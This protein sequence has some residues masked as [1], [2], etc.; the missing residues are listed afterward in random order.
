MRQGDFPAP[1]RLDASV[2]AA[3]EA[4]C[5]K[6]MTLKPSDRYPS[7]RALADDIERWLADEPVAAYR[8][9]LLA[10]ISRGAR[11]HKVAAASASALLVAAVV[12]L[13]AGTFLLGREQQR[14][15]KARG[16]AQ[17]N[18]ER[19]EKARDAE[20]KARH[21]A[22]D[23]RGKADAAKRQV[24]RQL[25]LSYLDRGVN[26]MER[27]D[28]LQGY[29]ILGQAYHAASECADLRAST[30][31]SWAPGTSTCLAYSGTKARSLPWRSARTGRRSPPRA[32]TGQRGCG[33]QR[34]ANR[35]ARQ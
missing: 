26:E 24:Q 25:I 16:D 6:A 35:W 33:T 17:T 7:A 20:S 19:A 18:Y 4:I 30:R 29:A 13:S 14:T 34:R 5:L 11:R 22:E 8:D 3:L 10:R 12:G 27:G 28:P 32:T 1:R 31:A 2:P 15:E 9:P 23:E 21:V